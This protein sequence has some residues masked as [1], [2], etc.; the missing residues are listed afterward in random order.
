MDR[1]KFSDDDDA[2]EAELSP[3]ARKEIALCIK[4]RADA[5]QL[6]SIAPFLVA[7]EEELRWYVRLRTA[8]DLYTRKSFEKQIDTLEKPLRVL[9]EGIERLPRVHRAIYV[10]LMRALEREASST[11]AVLTHL[12]NLEFALRGL[13]RCARDELPD[14]PTRAPN[15]EKYSLALQVARK[16]NELL[17]IKPTARRERDSPYE[18]VLA[19]VLREAARLT[20]AKRPGDSAENVH[21]LALSVLREFRRMPHVIVE[22]E[23]TVTRGHEP[24]PP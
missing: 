11:G 23:S 10:E 18:R 12:F 2:K 21:K 15:D 20:N 8:P 5:S 9:L 4:G 22:I 14:N 7:L 19:V 24:F 6:K 3:K 17:G 1:W 16:L 13:R